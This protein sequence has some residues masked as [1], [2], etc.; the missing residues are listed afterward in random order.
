MVD[1]VG[2]MITKWIYRGLFKGEELDLL[3]VPYVLDRAVEK[4][5]EEGSPSYEWATF[6]HIGA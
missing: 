1:D 3:D 6:V 4:L 2:P 5:S